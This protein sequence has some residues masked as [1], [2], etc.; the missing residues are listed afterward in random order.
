MYPAR[1]PLALNAPLLG[2]P[3]RN[4]EATLMPGD[5]TRDEGE[6]IPKP[7]P[8]HRK[9]LFGHHRPGTDAGP[10][11]RSKASDLRQQ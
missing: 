2:S 10:P 6:Q 11:G 4:E 1:T 3:E 9:E 8:K 5:D 7:T